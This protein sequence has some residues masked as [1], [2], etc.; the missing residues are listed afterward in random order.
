MDNTT[1]DVK[2]ANLDLVTGVGGSLEAVSAR[3]FLNS[4]V[5]DNDTDFA[6]FDAAKATFT[7]SAAKVITWSGTI[8]SSGNLPF[9]ESQL[10]LWIA[11]AA[12]GVA[13][14]IAGIFYY[15]GTDLIG[16]DLLPAQKIIAQIGDSV[17]SVCTAP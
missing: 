3:P 5:I 8:R 1:Y 15:N 14:T 10:L 9:K 12:P 16:W 7:G 11:T 2:E 13:E 6:D 4:L 17:Q